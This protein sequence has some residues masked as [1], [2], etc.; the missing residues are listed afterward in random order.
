MALETFDLTGC[1]QA[2]SADGKHAVAARV[3]GD[4]HGDLL[5]AGTIPDPFYRDNE[6]D[7]HWIGE[8]D[9]TFSRAFDVPDELLAQDRVLLRCEGLDTLATVR[10]NGHVVGEADNMHRTWE[11]DVGAALR[12]GANEIAITLR[13]AMQHV[14]TMNRQRALPAWGVGQHKLDGGGWIR[15]EPC[16]FGWDWGPVLVTCGIWRDIRLVAF[17]PAR[18]A[19]SV[20]QTTRAGRR[21]GWPCP[22]PS[23]RTARTPLR[24]SVT[25]RAGRK[26]RGARR[27]A[28]ARH[29]RAGRPVDPVDPKLW[30]P[31]GMGEQPLYEVVVDLQDAAGEVLDA[32]DARGTAHAAAC[33]G[34]G[35]LGRVVRL[36]R[37]RQAV[38][39]Q[40]RQLDPG[41]RRALAT[42]ARRLPRD[43][44]PMPPRRT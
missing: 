4:I 40:G 26:R 2:V 18:C 15:K 21:D 20:R 25:V 8:T 28:R 23:R 34:E 6:K 43:S 38:L 12:P 27:S 37:E 42:D 19:T 5:A 36:R 33:A 30:W 24:A 16:N 31:N 1:W 39:R 7:L 13:S 32:C 35:P 29:A 44:S 22:P 17:S 3:P 9:W 10:V 41:R 11:F 14:R